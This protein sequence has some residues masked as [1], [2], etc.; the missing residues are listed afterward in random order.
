[1]S[2]QHPTAD[3]IFGKDRRRRQLQKAKKNV[4]PNREARPPR[5]RDWLDLTGD[6][7]GDLDDDLRQQRIMPR[8]E[9][10]RQRALVAQLYEDDRP[11]EAGAPETVGGQGRV[12]EVST[13]LCRV[14]IGARTL[15]CGLRGSL[16]AQDTGFTN[17]VTVGDQ[18]VIS[19]DGHGQGVIEQVLPRRSALTRQDPFY[20]H[21][22]QLVAANIDQLLIIAAWRSPHIWTEL[23]DRYLI[24]AERSAITPVICVNKID[25][26]E[27]EAEIER[28]MQPYRA[29]GYHV[30]LTSA[31]CGEGVAELRALMGGKISVLAGLSG[32]G[33]SSL[34]TAAQP[35][36]R[37]RV[38]AVNEDHGQG[39]HTTTQTTMLPFGTDGYVIDTPGIR[40]FGLGGLHRAELLAFYPDLAALA[41]A[42][43]FSNCT[44]LHEPECAVRAG[45]EAGQISP[46]RYHNYAKIWESLPD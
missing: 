21:L 14:Q 39:R 38:G 30:L 3:D 2:K 8:G 22:R 16:S 4:K 44:H 43:R 29:L 41:G 13:A 45:A 9:R 36:F 32:V 46:L 27:D 5:R 33:K 23:I 28:V 1:M 18:V 11:V 15:L 37:L 20:G 19:E 35:E 12:I 26:A 31:T 25:L 24:T 40:E 42:C 10:D 34:L 17:V 6:D 7:A